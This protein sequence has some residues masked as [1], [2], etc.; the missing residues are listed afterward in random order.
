MLKI[1]E[2]SAFVLFSVG[3]VVFAGYLIRRRRGTPEFWVLLGGTLV[4]LS[5]L[6]V[7]PKDLGHDWQ[8]KSAFVAMA[9]AA[10][11]LAAYLVS[12]AVIRRAWLLIDL[13]TSV[14]LYV[15]AFS[16]VYYQ[17]SGYRSD[18]FAQVAHPGTLTRLDAVYFALTTATTV[19]FGDIAPASQ[20][21]RAIV[22]L[23]LVSGLILLGGV[24]AL[25]LSRIVPHETA[26]GPVLPVE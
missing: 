6:L 1:V 22:S 10:I 18:S 23:Q 24:V 12:R 16:N 19:G 4:M 5:D 3:Y 14:I 17:L 13:A 8:T 9:F 26:A 15:L 11:G 7:P 2:A 25:G 20:A 21:A